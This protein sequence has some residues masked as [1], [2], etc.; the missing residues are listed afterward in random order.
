M[1]RIH[2]DQRMLACLNSY[3][4]TSLSLLSVYAAYLMSYHNKD[5]RRAYD[6]LFD[7][8]SLQKQWDPVALPLPKDGF[9]NDESVEE[10]GEKDL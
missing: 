4:F 2:S 7:M 10:S 5:D 8:L 6:L 3:G 9:D 1:K